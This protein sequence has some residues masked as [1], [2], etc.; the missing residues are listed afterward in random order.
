VDCSSLSLCCCR[1]GISCITQAGTRHSRGSLEGGWRA[2][3]STPSTCSLKF[4]AQQA[5]AA[6]QESAQ[7]LELS[8]K[9]QANANVYLRKCEETEQALIPTSYFARVGAWF[10]GNLPSQSGKLHWSGSA[11]VEKCVGAIR[12]PQETRSFRGS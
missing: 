6:A 1:H 4:A 2:P 5:S 11:G 9:A 10:S 12:A 3:G 8:R 7:H